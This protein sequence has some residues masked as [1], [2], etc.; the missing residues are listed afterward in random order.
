MPILF[1]IAYLIPFIMALSISSPSVRD[2]V[3]SRCLDTMSMTSLLYSLKLFIQQKY[4]KMRQKIADIFGVITILLG[5]TFGYFLFKG[6]LTIGNNDVLSKDS[7]L[8][9]VYYL[10]GAFF[11]S[12]IYI[13]LTDHD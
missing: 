10:V 3:L 2:S 12:L 4:I 11:T 7:V 9:A 1:L 13:K 5:L 6:F 8:I